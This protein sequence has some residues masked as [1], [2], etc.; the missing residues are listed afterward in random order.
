MLSSIFFYYSVAQEGSGG[1]RDYVAN[2][3]SSRAFYD[4]WN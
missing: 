2:F 1:R 3:S 4:F